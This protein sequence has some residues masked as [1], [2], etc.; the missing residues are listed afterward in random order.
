MIEEERKL[1]TSSLFAVGLGVAVLGGGV[2]LLY[3]GAKGGPNSGDTPVVLVGASITFK[4]ESGWTQDSTTQ[5]YFASPDNAVSAIAIKS[6]PAADTG[7]DPDPTDNQPSSD[8]F[9]VNVMNGTSWE[10]D[11]YATNPNISAG[12]PFEVASITS[13]AAGNNINLHKVDETGYFCQDKKGNRISFGR[14][15]DCSDAEQFTFSN[16]SFKVTA[17]ATNLTEAS[18][19]LNCVD[20]NN[21][22]GQCKIAFRTP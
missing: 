12:T 15:P 17:T 16:V 10:I 8:L 2:V 9:R 7:D 4:A 19:T 20:L 11:E 1:V 6:K 3:A 18:G 22:P 14:K 13:A 5:D 21:H